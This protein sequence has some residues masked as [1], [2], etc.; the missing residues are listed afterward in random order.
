V[1]LAS[2]FKPFGVDDA[3]GRKENILEL[4]H[5]QLS[6]FQGVFSLRHR[7]PSIGLHLIAAN[8]DAGATV[9]DYPTESRFVAELKR[10]Y[11]VVGI[12]GIQ[13]NFLKVKRMCELVR[14]HAPV[15]TLVV[16]GFAA[17]IRNAQDLFGADRLC[18]G[19]GI[20]FMRDLLGEPPA[21]ELRHPFLTLDLVEY[22][23]IPL[24]LVFPALRLAFG[25]DPSL[26]R[27]HFIATG[28]GC[29]KGCEFCSTS[30]F[31]DCRHLPFMRTGR[32]IYEAMDRKARASGIRAFA[33]IGDDNFFL[34]RARVEELWRL[35]RE[36]GQDYKIMLSFGSTDLLSAFDP[37]MLAEAGFDLIWIG[38]ESRL[39]PFAKNRKADPREVIAGLHRFGVK[40]ILS[41][42]L[43]FDDHTPENIQDDIDYHLGFFPAYSQ[44]SGLAPAEGTP[45]Y[46]RLDEDGRILH[47]LPLE[48]RHAFKQIWFT[49]P[50]FS[51]L[52]SERIQREAYRRD[53]LELGPSM[54]RYQ[55]V[56]ARSLAALAASQSPTLRAR[57]ARLRGEAPGWKAAMLASIR[58]A[59]DDRQ[60][61]VIRGYL[62]ELGGIVGPVT[63]ADRAK[64][65][66]ILGFAAARRART[67][68]GG[69]VIQPRTAL[70]RYQGGR[71]TRVWPD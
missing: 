35:Q 68:I 64:A 32:E 40:T 29:P 21:F 27:S 50:H 16:G 15:A 18:V 41:S 8:L 59:V 25:A 4:M 3:Y 38:I 11:D 60:R 28:L 67:F 14:R 6:Q 33:F 1:L 34:D 26:Y 22:L 51:P 37:E 24:D 19:E 31:F 54:L 71:A 39:H 44:F 46:D 13:P 63:L 52:A 23:G 53:F 69:D 47:S 7:F 12:S 61:A 30:Y 36:G 70:I 49:H 42:I 43:F 5:N 2:V 48:E 58:L 56:T 57:A 66:A 10:G 62:D 65:A 45:L 17:M 55:I 20:R 9:L